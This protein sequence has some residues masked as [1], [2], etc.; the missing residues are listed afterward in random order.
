M[1]TKAIR[2]LIKVWREQY[3]V[4]MDGPGEEYA[5]EA[6]AE[7]LAIE[8]AARA[9]M[10]WYVDPESKRTLAAVAFPQPPTARPPRSGGPDDLRAWME[11][12]GTTG[13]AFA[14]RLGLTAETVSRY[15]NGT[16]VPPTN[17]AL[18]IEYLTGGSVR[19]EAWPKT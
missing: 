4:V 5:D 11:A 6:E 14:S 3:G 2:E 9:Y 1:S 18:A 16:M 12:T 15:L 8:K 7:V 10:A 13:V 19:A 17:T